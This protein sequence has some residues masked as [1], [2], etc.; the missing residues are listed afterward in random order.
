METFLSNLES[1]FRKIYE[2]EKKKKKQLNSCSCK[3]GVFVPALTGQ[4]HINFKID[5]YTNDT[6]IIGY[7]YGENNSLR[8]PFMPPSRENLL[9]KGK[10]PSTMACTLPCSNPTIPLCSS[11]FPAMTTNLM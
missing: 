4:Y 8:T 6:L 11:L 9:S 10:T 2:S 5:D 7:Y 1:S 3:Y